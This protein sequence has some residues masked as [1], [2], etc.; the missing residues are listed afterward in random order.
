MVFIV[1]FKQTEFE[2]DQVFGSNASNREV[3]E[4][5]VLPFISTNHRH[6]LT[7]ICFG[8]TGSGSFYFINFFLINLFE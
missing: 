7:Y 2:F 4:S 5:T 6:N 1:Y 8:Q 3:F